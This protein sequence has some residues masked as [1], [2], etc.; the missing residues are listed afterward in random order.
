M[1]SGGGQ[2]AA[3]RRGASG[4]EPH[5]QPLHLTWRPSAKEG[6]KLLPTP[7]SPPSSAQNPG[8]SPFWRGRLTRPA[9]GKQQAWGGPH[10]APV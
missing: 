2:D 5:S 3:A 7:P 6:G 8:K 9:E 10:R 1:Q 4:S